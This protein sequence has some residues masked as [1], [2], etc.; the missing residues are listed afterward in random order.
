MSTKEQFKVL[1][2]QANLLSKLSE[3]DITTLQFE[4][5]RFISIILIKYETLKQLEQRLKR[6]NSDS[7]FN[8][9]AAKKI[10]VTPDIATQAD[11]YKI[12]NNLGFSPNQIHSIFQFSSN[13]KFDVECIVTLKTTYEISDA[14]ICNLIEKYKTL[15]ELC[16]TIKKL[17]ELELSTDTSP[18]LTSKQINHMIKT[19]KFFYNSQYLVQNWD[20]INKE[21]LTFDEIRKIIKVYNVDD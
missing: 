21:H 14:N 18:K 3:D 1:Y 19:N 9:P 12:L 6:K 13:L 10:K 8:E 17:Y 16:E 20:N 7:H 2:S 5:D 15:S 11:S 4:V